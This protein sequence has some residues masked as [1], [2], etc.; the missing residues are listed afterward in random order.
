MDI[1]LEKFEKALR[2]IQSNIMHTPLIPLR[3]IQTP[4]GLPIYLKAESLQPSG[5]FK[6]RGATY[7]LSLLNNLQ[8]EDGVVAFSTGNHAQAVAY[9]AQ[10]LGIPATIVMSPDAKEFK[11]EAT[12]QYGANIIMTDPATREAVA[13]KF[14]QENNATLIHPYDSL[15]VITGQG[16]IS[17]EILEKILP[18]TIF[19]PIGG[20]GLIAGIAIAAKKI[21][22]SIQIIGVEPEIENDAFLSFHSGKRMPLATPSNTIADAIKIPMLGEIAFPLI[23]QYVDDVMTVTEKQIAEATYLSGET[24]HL[25]VEPAGALALAGALAYKNLLSASLPVVCI[26]SGG[27]TT[28]PSLCQLSTLM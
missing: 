4:Q 22:P 11:V 16:T 12:R 3:T 21:N 28:F 13:Q 7:C 17:L 14:A 6:I 5:S 25:F 24:A 9:A 18:G 26:A 23:Q 8:R 27:N 2:V 20:G 10:Q 19:V 1:A 15:N